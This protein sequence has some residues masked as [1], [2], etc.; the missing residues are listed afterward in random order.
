MKLY[1]F[2]CLAASYAGPGISGVVKGFVTTLPEDDPN[3][4]SFR[5]PSF[6]EESVDGSGVN[7]IPSKP[8]PIIGNPPKSTAPPKEG[9]GEEGPEIDVILGNGINK[10]HITILKKATYFHVKTVLDEDD[11]VEALCGI[12][13]IGQAMAEK[14]LAACEAVGEQE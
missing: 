8:V 7:V 9:G 12:D 4:E 14:I 13:G 3:I 11:P 6:K 2:T 10:K 1:K 5:N